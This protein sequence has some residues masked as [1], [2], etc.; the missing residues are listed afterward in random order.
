MTRTPTRRTRARPTRPQHGRSFS[1]GG[2][3]ARPTHPLAGRQLCLQLLNGALQAV[4]HLLLCASPPY[5]VR[6]CVC[7]S[8][9]SRRGRESGASWCGL[10]CCCCCSHA[11][12]ERPAGCAPAAP[13]TCS[14]PPAPPLVALGPAQTR[15][16][17]PSS[18]SHTRHTRVT[19]RYRG[20]STPSTGRGGRRTRALCSASSSEAC[21]CTTASSSATCFSSSSR[22]L[23]SLRA[24][25]RSWSCAACH[26]R[27]TCRVCVCACA[28]PCTDACRS[29]ARA[30]ER[31][32]SGVHTK[33]A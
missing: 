24:A 28:A 33:R 17:L 7:V 21:R 15:W 11:P 5:T 8:Y 32:G 14:P 9:Q 23:R 25:L 16:P 12:P 30:P 26:V 13:G 19:T 18:A 22:V 6:V 31:A 10:R 27:G 20:T 29:T 4:R 2:G 3:G 1:T